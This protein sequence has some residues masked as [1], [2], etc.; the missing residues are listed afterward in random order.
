MTVLDKIETINSRV[1]CDK[2]ALHEWEY[3]MHSEMQLTSRNHD[4]LFAL[5]TRWTVEHLLVVRR[6]GSCFSVSYR[7]RMEQGLYGHRALHL[8]VF[9]SSFGKKEGALARK[10]CAVYTNS[11]LSVANWNCAKKAKRLGLWWQPLAF[12][13]H[14]CCGFPLHSLIIEYFLLIVQPCHC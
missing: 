4:L 12:S 10:S 13:C 2:I 5:D 14:L 9:L 6:V 3:V 7:N 8:C 11:R 1:V